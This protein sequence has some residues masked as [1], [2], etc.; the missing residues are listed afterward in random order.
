MIPS[1]IDRSAS[2]L[3]SP[4]LDYTVG[5]VPNSV[6]GAIEKNTMMSSN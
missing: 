4:L 6:L 5:E 2:L 3:S 1:R